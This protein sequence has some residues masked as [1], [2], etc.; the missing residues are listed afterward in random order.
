MRTLRQSASSS[1][2]SS[3]GTEV[4]EPWPISDA[5]ETMVIRLSVPMVTQ[6]PALYGVVA[7]KARDA[8]GPNATPMETAPVPTRND[9]RDSAAVSIFSILEC[10]VM[11]VL[12]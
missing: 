8:S 2:A 12:P 9:R 5:G 11:L 7:A 4:M 6:A 10:L 3:I 1:S